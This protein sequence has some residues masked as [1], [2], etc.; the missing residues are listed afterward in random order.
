MDRFRCMPTPEPISISVWEGW[1][2]SLGTGSVQTACAEIKSVSPA[3]RG[4]GG[5]LREI[6]CGGKGDRRLLMRPPRLYYMGATICDN[7]LLPSWQWH[8]WPWQCWLISFGLLHAKNLHSP[9]SVGVT[10]AQI[11]KGQV[12]LSGCNRCQTA[13]CAVVTSS[14]LTSSHHATSQ[15]HHDWMLAICY[16]ENVLLLMFSFFL[17]AS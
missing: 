15:T 4:L 10:H 12:S 9:Q 3:S 11:G 1:A 17:A 7:H 8:L 2:L 5:F 6:R 13:L 16:F 14:S